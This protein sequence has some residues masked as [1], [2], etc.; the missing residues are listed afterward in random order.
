MLRSSEEEMN[1]TLLSVLLP[2]PPYV[3]FDN[4]NEANSA[5]LAAVITSPNCRFAGRILGATRWVEVPALTCWLASGSNPK[6][7]F[8]RFGEG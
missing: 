5:T 8:R 1:K 7:L 3:F 2:A 4:I 6:F